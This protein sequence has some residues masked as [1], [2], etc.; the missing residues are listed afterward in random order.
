MP[1]WPKAACAPARSPTGWPQRTRAWRWRETTLDRAYEPELWRLKGELLLEQSKV[2]G[3]RVPER[4]RRPT[5]DQRPRTRDPERRGEA[6]ACFQRALELARA[7]Q[8]KSLE[9]RA[10]TSLARAWQA[11][12]RT[13]E[14]RKLLGGV[15]KWF[16]TRAGTA[17][18]VE[19]RA[20]LGE[21]DTVELCG[22]SWKEIATFGF[23]SLRREV[24]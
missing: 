18:L 17:D 14:A 16:G 7:S 1:F 19:A 24:R 23:L 20:L 5:R 6:E 10:A 12:G 11:R 9:L 13:A 22:P 2:Q 8:A 3:P 4:Q 15:C 21:L